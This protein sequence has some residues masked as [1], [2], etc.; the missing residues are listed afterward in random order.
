MK[1]RKTISLLT[2]C[3]IILYFIAASYGILSDNGNGQYEYKSIHG[4]TISIYGKGLYKNDSVSVASQAI[5]Q[6]IVTI[7]LGIPLLIISLY[8]SRKGLIKGRL[9]LTGTLG[10]FLYTYTSYSFL[11]MYNSLFLIYVMLMSL[12][13]FAFTLAMMSF[14]IQDLSLY[15]DEKLPVKFLGCFLIFIAF[16]IGMMWLGRIVPSLINNTLPNGLEHYTTLVIQA[17]D[18]GFLVPTGIISGILVIKKE[19]NWI[20]RNL[21]LENF[22]GR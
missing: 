4:K 7:I 3:I 17:L 14:D 20:S 1:F 9:L 2:L 19:S 8:L 11:S 16:A 10:Y 12:S 15:F 6:D 18:L 21:A 5:A 22:L 13:F